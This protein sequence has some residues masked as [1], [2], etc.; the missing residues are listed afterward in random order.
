MK[1]F[2]HFF[3]I[4]FFLGIFI[5]GTEAQTQGKEKTLLTLTNTGSQER[6]ATDQYMKQY[7]ENPKNASEY[8]ALQ[9]KV[10]N[11]LENMKGQAP[12]ANPLII[13]VAIHYNNPITTAN[14]QCL[15]DAAQAQIDQMNLDFSGCNTNAVCDWINAGCDN[16]GGTAGADAMPDDGACIQFCLGDQNLPGGEDNIGGYAITVGDYTWAN[17]G[18]TWAGWLNIFVSDNPTAGHGLGNGIL[19]VAPLGGAGN[20]NGNGVFVVNTA[21]GSQGFGGCTSGG[22]LDTGAPYDGGGTLTHEVGHYFGLDHTFS[23]N[24]ADTP[25]QTNPNYGCPTVNT[26]TC[27]ATGCQGGCDDYAGNFNS[28]KSKSMGY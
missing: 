20:P 27:T 1:F 13:P 14:T 4:I 7:L 21:F 24:L 19:G 26:G 8:E 17:A 5:S 10:A 23:D 18:G 3:T 12:C 2:K 11:E 9:I 16:F 15:I 22:P 6:C 28:R 25:P